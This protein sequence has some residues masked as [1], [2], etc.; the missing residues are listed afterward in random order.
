MLRHSMVI[1]VACGQPWLTK[2]QK[3]KP[4]I[5]SSPDLEVLKSISVEKSS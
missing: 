5:S 3:I 4:I 1:V 2:K